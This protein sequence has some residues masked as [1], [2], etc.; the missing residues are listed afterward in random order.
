MKTRY[1][2]SI[3]LFSLLAVL[4]MTCEKDEKTNSIPAIQSVTVSPNTIHAN[5]MVSI[6]VKATDPDNDGL[7]YAYT[8][9]GGSVTGSGPIVTWTA[10][11][12]EGAHSVLVSV[13]D[14]K[15]GVITQNAS[16]NVLKPVTQVSG[17]ASFVAGVSGDLSNAKVSLYTTLENFELNQPV[18]NVAV[19]GSGGNVT[20]TIPD[21]L[22]GNYYLSVW[23]DNNNSQEL[24]NKDFIGIYGVI[25][26]GAY[27]FSELQVRQGETFNC[28]I[29]MW[30]L[31]FNTAPV[32]ASFQVY[33][34]TL[35]P[36]Q[37]ANVSVEAIDAD[38]DPL[39]Y[40][41]FANGGTIIG[42]GTNVLW[43]APL[44]PG[45]YQISVT[46]DDGEGG[47]DQDQRTVTVESPQTKITGTAK[48]TTGVIGDLSNAR[49]AVYK[50]IDDWFDNKPVKFTVVS[51]S[52]SS[53]TYSLNDLAPGTYYM[54]LWKDNDNDGDWSAGDFIGL[55]SDNNGML[56][57]TL[58]TG[59]TININLLVTVL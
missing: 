6:D 10:P 50:S 37:K 31:D 51:G 53:V 48:L 39:T 30:I 11:S 4:F 23:K 3:V 13:S 1:I 21:V 36:G 32:I 19:Q 22:P 25:N 9:T 20:F 44:T 49:V 45:D 35:Q 26:L 27:Q 33:P 18:R 28:K 59:Q 57:I 46:V 47:T 55:H 14:G 58:S 24:D 56:P 2:F 54:D 43:E 41:Y 40:M 8:V 12:T 29:D 16:L 7:S 38:N 52:G 34:T 17:T 42:S 5:G 15:G